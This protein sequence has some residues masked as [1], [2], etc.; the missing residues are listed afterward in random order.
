MYQLSD[1][2][3]YHYLGL[4]LLAGFDLPVAHRWNIIVNGGFDL[5]YPNLGTNKHVQPFDYSWQ[6]HFDV[7]VRYSRK[8]TNKYSYVRQIKK[9]F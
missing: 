4:G 1:E 8:K 3:H 7:G 2:Y 9:L 5:D 6:Y